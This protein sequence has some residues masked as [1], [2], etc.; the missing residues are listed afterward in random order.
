MHVSVYLRGTHI[1]FTI[2]ATL[3][4]S[5][6]IP[7]GMYYRPKLQKTKM[8]SGFSVPL[9]ICVTL[10]LKGVSYQTKRGQKW[11]QSKDIPLRTAR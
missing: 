3:M 5:L 10:I 7:I 1:S 9:L 11:N 8:A 2:L 6:P 4:M